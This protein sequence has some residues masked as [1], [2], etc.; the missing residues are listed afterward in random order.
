MPDHEDIP[1]FARAQN[2]DRPNTE[3]RVEIPKAVMSVI[4][5]H[6][7]AQGSAKANRQSVVNAVLTEWA[8]K[9]WHEA[10]LVLR[11][12]PCNPAGPESTDEAGG[13]V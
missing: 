8:E 9:R 3:L 10:S 11:L 5:A 7:M 6:W 1:M 2:T 12:V 13:T 4:D